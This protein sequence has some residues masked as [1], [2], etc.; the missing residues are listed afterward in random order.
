MK[1]REL[2]NRTLAFDSPARVPRQMWLLPLAE[3]KYPEMVDKIQQK[4]P[5]DVL[6]SPSCYRIDLP[7]QGDRHA[8]GTYVDEWGCAF[9]KIEDGMIGEV[10]TPLLSDWS[11]MDLV[12]I[13]TERLSV[14]IDQVN[15]FCRQTD[16]FVLAGCCPRP[17]ERLQFIR[18]SE[19]TYY[20]LMDQPRE[21]AVLLARIQAFY[22]DEFEL[23]AKTDVDAL[24]FMDDWGGQESMLI[25]PALW[26]QMFKPL[27]EAYVEIAHDHG[28]YLFMHSDG[29]ILDII[30]DLVK[31][32]VDA[33]NAQI[34]CMKM[35]AL[36]ELAAGKI[37]FW[38]EMDRQY[39]LPYGTRDE[40]A[41]AARRMKDLLYCDGGLIAQCEFG[42][43]A[44]PDNVYAFLEAWD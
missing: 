34:F 23:W 30:P 35:E 15:E 42:A 33:I 11:Q 39:L 43:G 3:R 19:N 20:D 38:G 25:S 21:L 26:R 41:E 24:F 40:I 37:T 7:V 16:R 36:S 6:S 10:K 2:V 12:R 4:F 14:D 1:P 28:K 8:K 22:I 32:G 44:N 17:F 27:Y 29:Y 5:D 13:P 31:I 18:G 9:E